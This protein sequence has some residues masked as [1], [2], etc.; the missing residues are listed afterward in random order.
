VYYLGFAMKAPD[1][2]AREA[3]QPLSIYGPRR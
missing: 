3:G 1:L 2:G